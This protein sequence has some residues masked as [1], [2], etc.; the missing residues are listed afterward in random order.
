MGRK[1]RKVGKRKKKVE[2]IDGVVT[3]VIEYNDYDDFVEDLHQSKRKKDSVCD[4][5]IYLQRKKKG[6]W[7]VS[8]VWDGVHTGR[9]IEKLKTWKSAYYFANMWAQDI[10]ESQWI[11]F[12]Q[13]VPPSWLA[14]KNKWLLETMNDIYVITSDSDLMFKYSEAKYNK[15]TDITVTDVTQLMKKK[16]RQEDLGYLSGAHIIYGE[17][18]RSNKNWPQIGKKAR[19]KGKQTKWFIN[20]SVE[21]VLF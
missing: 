19:A 10:C 1:K 9:H 14:T 8:E 4:V 5:H 21:E 7:D 3:D 12:V 20:Q 15:S 16:D 18:T 6:Q 2:K 13:I 11:D 17:Q